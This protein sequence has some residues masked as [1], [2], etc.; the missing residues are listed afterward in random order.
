MPRDREPLTASFVGRDAELGALVTTL[1][2]APAVAVV[3]G[4]SGIGKTRLVAQL[5]SDPS[6]AGRRHVVGGCRRIGEPF[7]LGPILEGLLRH[8]DALTGASLSPV[9]GALRPLLPELSDVLPAAQPPLDDSLAERH[10]VFRALVELLGALGPSLLVV[11]DLHWADEQ[12]I[13]FLGYL[14]MAPP[15]ELVLVMTSRDDLDAVRRTVS[16]SIPTSVARVH[17]DLAPLDVDETWAMAARIL[18]FDG[19]SG[20]FAAYLWGR[21]SGLP[22][23]IEELLALMLS[24]Q[25]LVRHG[26]GWVRRAIDELDVPP[27]I[28]DAV[29][30][31]IGRLSADARAVMEAAAVLQ[32]PQPLDVLVATAGR[33][34]ETVVDGIDEALDSGVLVDSDDGIGFRHVL[35]AQAV[36]DDVPPTR[37]RHMHARAAAALESLP[38]HSLGQVAHHLRQAGGPQ[39]WAAAVERAADKAVELRHDAQARR[40]LEDLLRNGSLPASDRGRVAVKLAWAARESAAGEPDLVELLASVLDEGVP[41]QWRGELRFLLG[42]HLEQRGGDPAPRREL[43]AQAVAELEHRPDLQ[44]WAMVGLGIPTVPE[45]PVSELREWLHRA[46]EIVPTVEDPAFRVFLWGKAAMV[47]VSLGDPAWV[48]LV[49]RVVDQTHGA[50]R[51]RREIKAYES[52]G[53]E[54]CYAGHHE[55]AARLLESGM[56]GAAHCDSRVLELRLLRSMVLLDFCTGR[57]DGLAERVRTMQDELAGGGHVRAA[58][59][60]VAGC[61]ALAHGELDEAQRRLT[62]VIA[63]V[64]DVGAYVLLPLPAAALVRLLVARGDAE[65]AVRIGSEVLAVAESHG[66][67][68]PAARLLPALVAALTAAGLNADAEA[69]VDRLAVALGELDAPLAAATLSE[70]RGHLAAAVGRRAVAAERFG[71]ASGSYEALGCGYE[72]AQAAEAAA[73]H[74][75]ESGATSAGQ[76][77]LHAALAAYRRLGAGWDEARAARTARAWG[78]SVPGRHRSGRRGY[79]DALSPR[80]SEVADLVAMGRSNTEIGR[81]LFLSPKTVEKHVSAAKRKLG[82]TTRADVVRLLLD[83]G[84]EAV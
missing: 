11:E 34:P 42:V 17:V 43:Y 47:L 5:R 19:L 29:L 50:P 77:Q 45:V 53:I 44:A 13:E 76:S 2:A 18:D 82:A 81:E 79:G 40:L 22:L 69:L 14:M 56:R 26:S 65:E 57:W 9:T 1:S 12:T 10:R 74:L 55:T 84:S 8:R 28:R 4:E 54:A 52:V 41:A 16:A 73:H 30:E 60:A 72:A 68:A 49:D 20:E 24:R 31:R 64:Q 27:R 3:A 39:L 66:L 80:E 51:S 33:S 36:Y 62:D 23:A 58:V 67:L 37:R 71:E 61:L 38:D 48:A 70:A 35:A 21:T 59:D 78:M 63:G 75:V 15:D 6:M 46:L 83:G 32:V 7:P 25:T